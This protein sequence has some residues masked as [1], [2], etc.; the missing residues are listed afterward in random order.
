MNS[1]QLTQ[2][3]LK[4]YQWHPKD[5]QNVTYELLK[6][7]YLI[8]CKQP[9]QLNSIVN[10]QLLSSYSAPD[11]SYSTS[12]KKLLKYQDKCSSPDDL[13]N[14]IH[15]KWSLWFEVKHLYFLS[16]ASNDKMKQPISD[17]WGPVSWMINKVTEKIISP[18]D[19]F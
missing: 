5:F 12:W 4:K 7:L 16:Q 8:A 11:I 3:L 15:L 6:I 9:P 2:R 18:A 1:F 10:K 19:H 17:N 13:L 14:L